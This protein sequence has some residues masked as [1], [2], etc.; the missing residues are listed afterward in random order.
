[1]IIKIGGEAETM[2]A[3]KINEVLDC[4]NDGFCFFSAGEKKRV[5][6]THLAIVCFHRFHVAHVLSCA[7]E[8]CDVTREQYVSLS[9]A[10]DNSGKEAE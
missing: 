7:R 3:T 4:A 6:C 2:H 1:M 8:L 9:V 5:H 10:N